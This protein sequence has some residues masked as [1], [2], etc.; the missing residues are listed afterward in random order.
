MYNRKTNVKAHEGPDQVKQKDGDKVGSS[1]QDE[2]FKLVHRKTKVW[3]MKDKE[4]T[5]AQVQDINSHCPDV[6]PIEPPENNM[7][8]GLDQMEEQEVNLLQP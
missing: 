5:N 2:D 3:R 8:A 4:D 6:M 7:F 1:K